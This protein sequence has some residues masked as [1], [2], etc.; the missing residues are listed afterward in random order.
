MWNSIIRNFRWQRNVDRKGPRHLAVVELE[1]GSSKVVV[2]NRNEK[3][4]DWESAQVVSPPPSSDHS[5]ARCLDSALAHVESSVQYVSVVVGDGAGIVRL[6]NFPGTPP[7][8]SKNMLDQAR[9][10]LGVDESYLVRHELTRGSSAKGE[11]PGRETPASGEQ[12]KKEYTV[13]AAAIKRELADQLHHCIQEAGLTPVSLLLGGVASINLADAECERVR[14]DQSAGFLAVGAHSSMLLLYHHKQLALARQFKTG[15][16]SLVE[17]LMASFD[18]DRKTAEEILASGSFDLSG[19]ITSSAN[20]WIHQ[21]G[22]SLDF[23]ERRFGQS[24]EKLHLACEGTGGRVLR[25][26]LVDKIGDRVGE[27]EDFQALQGLK[28]SADKGDMRPVDFAYALCE[29]VRIMRQG[30]GN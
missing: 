22:I 21:I 7:T 2:L 10:A 20:N 4:I 11:R 25:N 17:S 24:V 8:M 12:G 5:L 23:I 18:L 19:N 15:T 14:D 1:P 13:L 29:G 26:M 6:L 9:Q 3:A 27:W 28:S 30:T 16:R